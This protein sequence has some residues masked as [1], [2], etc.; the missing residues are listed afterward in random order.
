[1]FYDIF[2]DEVFY[3]REERCLSNDFKP[4]VF[5]GLDL[6]SK[7]EKRNFKNGKVT[8]LKKYKDI[9]KFIKI[10]RNVLSNNE[11][12]YYGKVNKQV[13]LKIFNSTGFKVKGFNLSLQRNN[14]KHIEKKHGNIIL[15][16]SRGQSNVTDYDFYLI[17]TIVSDADKIVNTYRGKCN[18]AIEFIKRIDSTIY[19]LIMYIS[20]RNHNLEVKTLFKCSSKKL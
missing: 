20:L 13:S 4:N 2:L 14:F 17:P 16:S 3:L 18:N 10:S 11:K 9:D 8:I 5:N 15:E 6:Y 12:L 1:M 7:K 19:H